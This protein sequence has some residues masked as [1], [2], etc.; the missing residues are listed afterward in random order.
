MHGPLQYYI[1]CAGILWP[2]P[3]GLGLFHHDDHQKS[4]RTGGR[5]WL[6]LWWIVGCG[7]KL[8]QV[9]WCLDRPASSE[10]FSRMRGS[11]CTSTHLFLCCW[12]CFN[13]AEGLL[14]LI[15]P[16]EQRV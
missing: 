1:I 11:A 9:E 5:V 8:K 13:L 3:P 14:V 15:D 4:A 6:G 10:L 12:A 7:I 2:Q 16:A